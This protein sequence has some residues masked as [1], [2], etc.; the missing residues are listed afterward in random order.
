MKKLLLLIPLTFLICSSLYSQVCG[1]PSPTENLNY[2]QYLDVSSRNG[3]E[4]CLDV[5]FHILRNS[6]GENAID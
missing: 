2:T 3:N 6:N 5:K 1:T 4:A